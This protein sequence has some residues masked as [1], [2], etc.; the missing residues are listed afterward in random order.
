VTPRGYAAGAS[1]V[2]REGNLGRIDVSLT[3]A[4]SNQQ[5]Q[6][7][8]ALVDG[9]S[10][11]VPQYSPVVRVSGAVNS[12]AS[13]TFQSGKDLNY[14][15]DA[16][17]GTL[18][19]GNRTASYVVQP[20][21]TREVY[22]HHWGPLPDGVPQP[23]AGSEVVVPTKAEDHSDWTTTLVPLTQALTALATFIYVLSR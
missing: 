11:N 14:Y 17:G 9:D 4:M 19:L 15:I 16:A 23:A 10:I 21:G 7:N 22:R 3:R 20:N 1:L 13:I 2:R 12:P 6:D 5:S 18:P 8:L